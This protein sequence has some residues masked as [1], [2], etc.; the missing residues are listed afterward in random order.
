VHFCAP[1]GDFDSWIAASPGLL[2]S[3]RAIAD[4]LAP[5]TNPLPVETFDPSGER[6]DGTY[7]IRPNMAQFAQVTLLGPCATVDTYWS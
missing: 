1:G 5:T 2:D 3:T 4:T 7:S 6:R